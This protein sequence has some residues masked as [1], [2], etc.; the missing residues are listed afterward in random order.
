MIVQRRLYAGVAPG[1]LLL[2]LAS[3]LQAQVAV[4]DQ[5][6]SVPNQTTSAGGSD[7]GEEIVVTGSRIRRPD[8]DT[9]APIVSL[10]STAILQT[11]NTNL[12]NALAMIPAL[13]NSTNSLD[14][15][16]GGGG[17]GG[18]GLNLTN[19]RNLGT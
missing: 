11:G 18:A 10:D 2:A 13:Q 3:P 17:I 15:A 4:Q 16:G 5:P 19:L 6:A 9:P 12:T 1:A 14:T 7:G 8:F